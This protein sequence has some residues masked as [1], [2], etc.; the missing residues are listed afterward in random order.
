MHV[1]NTRPLIVD[2]CGSSPTIKA[3]VLAVPK[4]VRLP[5]VP[6]APVD[7]VVVAIPFTIKLPY[8]VVAPV[9]AAVDDAKTLPPV[10]ILV[11]I[12]VDA[13]TAIVTKR[14]PARTAT[15]IIGN[16]ASLINES[17]LFIIT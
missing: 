13:L 6:I 5:W 2:A 10:V 15:I 1:P 3:D 14:T 11:E 7:A 4:T 8:M 17:E 12:V 16:R 9:I